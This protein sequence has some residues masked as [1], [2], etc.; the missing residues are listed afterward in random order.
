MEEIQEAELKNIKESVKDTGPVGTIVNVAKTV[1][2]VNNNS[3]FFLKK[4]LI[5]FPIG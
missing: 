1:E 3:H 2:Q 5:H 4:I